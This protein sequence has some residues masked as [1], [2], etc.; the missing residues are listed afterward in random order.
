MIKQTLEGT[1]YIEFHLLN[2]RRRKI[3]REK[4][5]SVKNKRKSIGPEVTSPWSNKSNSM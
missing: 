2:K 1:R 3:K 5:L 4:R